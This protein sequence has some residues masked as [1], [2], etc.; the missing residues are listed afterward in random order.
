M[1]RYEDKLKQQKMLH[2]RKRKESYAKSNI[3]R[4]RD[5]IWHTIILLYVYFFSPEKVPFLANKSVPF[6]SQTGAALDF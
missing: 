6:L 5:R 4:T 2:L 1:A 3:R